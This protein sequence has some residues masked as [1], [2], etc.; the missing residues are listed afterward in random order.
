MQTVCGGPGGT[1]PWSSV[2]SWWSPCGWRSASGQQSLCAVN[3]SG[4]HTRVLPVP[5]SPSP[6]LP[7]AARTTHTLRWAPYRNGRVYLLWQARCWVPV[8]TIQDAGFSR[9][10]ASSWERKA[11]AK[12]PDARSPGVLLKPHFWHLYTQGW[13][14]VEPGVMQHPEQGLKLLWFQGVLGSGKTKGT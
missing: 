4:K 2:V 7:V 12:V 3:D 8:G 9:G 5:A 6:S 1:A 10:L 14:A 13:G 11:S